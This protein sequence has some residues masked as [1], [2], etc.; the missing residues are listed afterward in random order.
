MKEMLDTCSANN[1]SVKCA[2]QDKCMILSKFTFI[3][4]KNQLKI[5]SANHYSNSSKTGL[6]IKSTNT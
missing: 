2:E 6:L 3:N 5:V 4:L 1:C